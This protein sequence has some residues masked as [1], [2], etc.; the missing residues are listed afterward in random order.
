[1]KVLILS[2]GTGGEMT[3]AQAV[4]ERLED[5]RHQVTLLDLRSIEGDNLGILRR[6]KWLPVCRAEDQNEYR[7]QQYLEE[8]SFDLIIMTHALPAVILSVLRN[9]GVPLPPMVYV[10][11]DYT[12]APF[13]EDTFCDSYVIPSEKLTAEF[14]RRGI[15]K[16]R[17][18]AA[19]IPVRKEFLT[20]K[21]RE[22]ARRAA[23]MDPE[24]YY[25]LLSAEKFRTGKLIRTI[26]RIQKYLDLHPEARLMVTGIRGESRYKLRMNYIHD[27]RIEWSS[28]E[29]HPAIYGRACDVMISGAGGSA[30]AE[31]AVLGVPLIQLGPSGVNEWH[32]AEF[33]SRYGM[34]IV[35]KQP[36]RGLLRALNALNESDAGRKM[37][38]A[39]HS[40]I[41][42]LAAAE[43][44]NLVESSTMSVEAGSVSLL[45]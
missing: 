37:V 39:Q 18:L 4:R 22:E 19:G 25:I 33:F 31:A 10:A 44:C 14:C 34:S 9:G 27:G 7:V 42:R 17:I 2:C 32:N 8:H 36:E 15:P 30:S 6:L 40:Y 23:G 1:M 5:H 45:V 3:A 43:I 16:D 12:C 41:S 13:I 29:I 20:G 28:E 21:S 38:R 35:V 11:S 24:G 26:W